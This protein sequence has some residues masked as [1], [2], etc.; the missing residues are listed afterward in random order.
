MGMTQRIA[1]LVLAAVLS[2][3]P[4]AAGASARSEAIV[5]AMPA[6]LGPFA[7]LGTTDYE[8]RHPGLGHSVR[9]LH[10][11]RTAYADV[12]VYDLGGGPVPD[13]VEAAAVRDQH[14]RMLADVVLVYRRQGRRIV[15]QGEVEGVAPGLRCTAFSFADAEGRPGYSLACLTGAGGQFVKVRLTGPANDEAIAAARRF[16]ADAVAAARTAAR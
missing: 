10:H 13:G 6:A 4:A 11:D 5:A 1:W 15:A 9:Y 3:T 16:A 2:A 7:R 12:Y 14:A 8:A